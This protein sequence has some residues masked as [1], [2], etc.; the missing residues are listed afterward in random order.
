MGIR[1]FPSFCGSEIKVFGTIDLVAKYREFQKELSL[2]VVDTGKGPL[3][4]R[5][6]IVGLKINWE[7]LLNRDVLAISEIDREIKIN[8]LMELFPNVFSTKPGKIT[9]HKEKLALKEGATPVFCQA[10]PVPFS[11]KEEVEKELLRMIDQGI[12][13]RVDHSEWATP[14]VVVKKS[15]GKIRICGDYKVTVNPNLMIDRYP[16][17][18]T[19]EL[20][21]GLE[22]AEWYSKLDCTEAYLQEEIDPDSRDL[23]TLNTHIGL[24]RPNVL[25][26]GVASA[27]GKFQRFMVGLLAGIPG[28]KAFYDDI[29]IAGKNFEEHMERLKLVLE[30]M[31]RY[32]V[33]INMKKCVFLADK[34]EYC[35]YLVDKTG[36][37]KI[38]AK[39]EAIK[40]MPSPKN[41]DQVRSLL[42]FIN[43]YSR[44]FKDLS[45]VIHPINELLR[46][47]VPFVWSKECERVFE[48]VKRELVSDKVLAHFDPRLP[49][50][51]ATDASPYGVGAVLSHR[52]PNGSERPIQYSSQ[53]LNP[54]QMKYC[55]LDKEAYA[56]MFGVRKFYQFLYGRQFVLQVDNKPLMQ[57][58]T[59]KKTLPTLTATRMKHYSVFLSM[60]DF[61]MEFK[62]SKNHCNADGMSRLPLA[63]D[64][65]FDADEVDVL[66]VSQLDLLP[67]NWKNLQEALVNEEEVKVLMQG[68]R[69]GTDVKA[70]SRFNVPQTEFSLIQDCLMRGHRVF[71]PSKFRSKVLS[72]L[73]S[74]HFGIV[75]MKALARDYIWWP[76]IDRDVEDLVKNCVDCQ[77]QRPELKKVE[78]HIWEPATEPFE[79]IHIDFAG[80]FCG[81]FY[82]IIVD[83]FSKWVEVQIMND[84]TTG[85]T[86]ERLDKFFADFGTCRVLVSDNGPQLTSQEFEMYLKS[87]GIFHK[88]S[89][90]YNPSTNGQAERY[91]QTLKQKLKSLNVG[92]GDPNLKK[93]VNEILTQYRITPHPVTGES[94]S[95]IVF[96][97]RLRSKLDLLV[98]E[99]NEKIE[100]IEDDSKTRNYQV[101]QRVMCRNY[102]G[103]KWEFGRVD[104]KLGKLHYLIRLD[105]GRLWK[106][107]INQVRSVGEGI[108]NQAENNSDYWDISDKGKNPNEIQEEQ[109]LVQNSNGS[110][111]DNPQDDSESDL[112]D[113]NSN[114]TV[115]KSSRIKKPVD[116][117][118]Y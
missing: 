20:F 13:E 92:V 72:E 2:Y 40:D 43:Y 65:G 110:E 91:V 93:K 25:M 94:P 117:L 47:D 81:K 19:S 82:L 44:F 6:W 46:D 105:D 69:D 112:F 104:R 103:E 31:N 42:G 62:S 7:R 14:I 73:H 102:I 64:N 57:I 80:R 15:N 60:F 53:S 9:G 18:T 52:Y 1:S 97:R 68:L 61:E 86:V 118:K 12:L 24:L 67:L 106:R 98:P 70:C 71:I 22:E 99:N 113:Q 23:L 74:A 5:D 88:L 4:G 75:R 8:E 79:R 87:K 54:T 101:G 38:R 17:P 95:Q 51:L 32:N 114:D 55:Q 45:T 41:K 33:R 56:I 107:H 28:V 48:F 29:K 26:Y 34:I 16:L 3:L 39:V 11:I 66:I 63:K 77:K 83:S 21:E 111:L 49:L 116:R 59:P 89:A 58:L 35:G 96:K 108:P 10:R 36:V 109:I 50:I 85:S 78:N 115:R 30:R 90:P 76:G 100:K 84:I 27:P 37:H